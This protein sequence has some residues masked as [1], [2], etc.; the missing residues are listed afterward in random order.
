ML[1]IRLRI[2]IDAR[3]YELPFVFLR[4]VLPRV[5]PG[6]GIRRGTKKSSYARG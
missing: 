4:P 5:A 6:F 3:N 2:L 1:M